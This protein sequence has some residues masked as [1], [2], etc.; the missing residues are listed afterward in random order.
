MNYK[1]CSLLEELKA[2]SKPGEKQSI[3]MKY[4]SD[5]LRYIIKAAY[6][7]FK[8]YHIKLKKK[9]IPLPG[10]KDLYDTREEIIRALEFCSESK[11]PKQ[12]RETIIPILTTLDKGS[13]DLLLG[14][15]DKNWKSGLGVKNILKV[16]PDIVKE[17][18]VQLANNYIDAISKKNYKKKKRLCSFKCDGLRCVA[19]RLDDVWKFRTRKG[20]EFLTLNHIKK[21]L[22]LLYDKFGYTFWDGEAYKHGVVFSD[23]QGLVMG[24]KKTGTAYN[25]DYNVFSAGYAENFLDQDASGVVIP[26]KDMFEDT[27]NIDVVEQHL[28]SD[29]DVY[30][31]LERAFKEGYEGIMLRDPDV[32][33]DFK[34]SDAL[35]KLKE[36]ELASL[37]E[38]Y[39]DCTIMDVLIDD[40]PVI[41]DGVMIIKSLITKLWVKQHAY[42]DL[43]CKVG[44]GF[45]LAFRHENPEELVD[46]IVEIKFQD[47]G[48]KG[49]MRF[50]RLYR[51]RED[52]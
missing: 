44:S 41:E 38:Q 9:E 45:D 15:L 47:Y 32:M 33:Y 6:D 24:F 50:P 21:D 8:L 34:R 17:F 48:S 39:A 23:I 11:S 10:V 12:N 30:T 3:I 13:Q 31:E 37:G 35:L 20:K 22:E 14:T 36:D 2:T 29:E 28:I 7:P 26:T 52:L 5:F 16:F 25:I 42:N 46:K 51:V 27:N 4:D 43:I 49:L 19:L 1:L 18:N 40:F